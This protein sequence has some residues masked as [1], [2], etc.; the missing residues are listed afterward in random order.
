MSEF[1]GG[2]AW[3][4]NE[5]VNIADARIPIVDAGFT[6]S[7]VTYDVASVWQG[8]FFRLEDHLDRFE[9]SQ[10]RLR[11]D[12]GV[13]REQTRQILFE[14][15]RRAGLQDAYVEV[16]ATRGTPPA[17]GTRDP[18]KYV[19][20]LYAFAIPYIWIIDPR[21]TPQG[22][23]LIIAANTRRIP[24]ESVDPSVKNFHWGDLTRGLF[25]AYDRGGTQVV[26]LDQDGN[27]TEGPGFN[28]FACKDN[29]L[30]TP[31]KGVL[32]GITRRTVLELA[33]QSG[34]DV[35]V[36]AMSSNVLKEAEEIFLTSTAGGIMP[37]AT[38]DGL[39]VGTSSPGLITSKI[40]E[41]YWH[42]HS[43]P[44]LATPVAY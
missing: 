43:D 18:R 41:L 5:Y 11:L 24:A 21:L 8:R 26:L 44:R 29:V 38:L 25:E 10:Q 22:P 2:C 35:V 31:D 20:K 7:D 34:M 12:T 14:C 40:H 17:G 19:N 28:I 36:Q 23:D 27:V 33:A 15:V 4:D 3:I 37:V 1:E 13:G 30:F 9:R 42:A 39:P 16:V 32:E 6:R